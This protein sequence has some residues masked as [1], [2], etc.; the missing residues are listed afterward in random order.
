M[1]CHN[2]RMSGC[3]DARCSLYDP[4]YVLERR[5]L[6]CICLSFCICPPPFWFFSSFVCLVPFKNHPYAHAYWPSYF[7]FPL[8]FSIRRIRFWVCLVRRSCLVFHLH[9]WLWVCEMCSLILVLAI[10][11]TFCLL[12]CAVDIEGSTG[13]DRWSEVSGMGGFGRD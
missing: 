5:L 11:F 4:F 10:R 6:F 7:L 1:L 8:F 13:C 2:G 9:A 12:S 3:K